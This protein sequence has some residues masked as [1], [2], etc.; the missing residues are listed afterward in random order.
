M[1]IER[2]YCI[3]LS[4]VATALV[5]YVGQDAELWSL[6]WLVRVLFTWYTIAP[7]MLEVGRLVDWLWEMRRKPRPDPYALVS[8]KGVDVP[9][10]SV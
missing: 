4:L 3:G 1:S 2:A 6:Q 9:P 7:L 5:R 10:K 8:V